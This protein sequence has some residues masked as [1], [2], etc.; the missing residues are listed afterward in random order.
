[1]RKVRKGGKKGVR[2]VPNHYHY[3]SQAARWFHVSKQYINGIPLRGVTYR[4]GM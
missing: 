2:L 4:R 1:M 3:V